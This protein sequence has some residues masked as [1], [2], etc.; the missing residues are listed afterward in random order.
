MQ[1]VKKH[2]K[3]NL[4]EDLGNADITSLVNFNLL[5]KFFMQKN[6]KINKTVSQSKFLKRVGIIERADIV[7]KKISFKDKS[8]I[9][10]NLQR[11]LHPKYMGELFK[12]IFAFKN[13]KKFSLGFD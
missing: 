12:V 13:N 2:K 6:L 11:L 10:F 9:Y 3:V 7:S 8:S 4:F 5:E 1:S